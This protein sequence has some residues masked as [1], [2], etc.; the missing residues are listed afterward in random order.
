MAESSQSSSPEHPVLQWIM[1]GLGLVLTLAA[2]GVIVHAAVQ[3]PSPPDLTA[4]VTATRPAA[5]GFIAQIEIRNLGRDT[6]AAVQV[7]GRSG[8]ETAS[9]TVDYVP[10]KGRTAVALAFPG[11]PAPVEARVT[12]W[13]EP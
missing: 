9:T 1:A 6:A 5:A 11:A 8:G 3:P 4:Q 12:G 10:G 2:A 7:E 13:S